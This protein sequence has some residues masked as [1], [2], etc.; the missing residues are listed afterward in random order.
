MGITIFL[1]PTS[2]LPRL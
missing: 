2:A 1:S